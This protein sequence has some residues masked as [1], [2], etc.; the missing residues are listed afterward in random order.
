M[1]SKKFSVINPSVLLQDLHYAW[2]RI[3]LSLL[4]CAVLY[5]VTFTPLFI[6]SPACAHLSPNSSKLLFILLH[7]ILCCPSPYCIPHAIIKCR[8]MILI[9]YFPWFTAKRAP[10]GIRLGATEWSFLMILLTS[11]FRCVVCSLIALLS[12]ACAFVKNVVWFKAASIGWMKVSLSEG[13]SPP[14]TCCWTM[15]TQ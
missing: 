9:I 8:M 4:V 1:I 13:H 11:A 15:L 7:L 2:I 3:L 5:V 10:S 6:S 12:S 14:V